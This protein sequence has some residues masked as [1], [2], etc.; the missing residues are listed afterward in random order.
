MKMVKYYR[1]FKASAG[2]KQSVYIGMYFLI[3]KKQKQNIS[4]ND[5]I[6]R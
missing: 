1:T 4:D 5:R 6:Q 2:L 3:T